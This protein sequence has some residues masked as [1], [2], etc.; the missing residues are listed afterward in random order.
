MEIILITVVVVACYGG[1]FALVGANKRAEK[2]YN[3]K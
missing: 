2:K 3:I 1:L